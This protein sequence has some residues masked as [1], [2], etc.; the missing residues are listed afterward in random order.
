MM[1]GQ[2]EGQE[3]EPDVRLVP[4]AP[5]MHVTLSTVLQGG[6]DLLSLEPP[7]WMP[8][9]HAP[10]CRLCSQDFTCVAFCWERIS[11]HID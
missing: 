2:V 5:P 4:S 1:Q 11:E 10:A 7:K 3:M 6:G 8:D 9:S